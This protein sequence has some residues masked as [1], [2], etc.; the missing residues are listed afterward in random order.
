MDT[1]QVI[2]LRDFVHGIKH[3]NLNDGKER[4]LTLMI[5]V[6]NAYGFFNEA[7]HI[8]RWDDAKERFYVFGYNSVGTNPN[9]GSKNPTGF[10]ELSIVDYGQIQQFKV[11]LSEVDFDAVCT[12]LGSSLMPD[13]VRENTRMKLFTTTDPAYYI[14]KDQETHY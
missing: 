2:E 9:M 5:L 11:V 14:K 1:P 4:P 7:I 6:D 10:G 8:V 12:A 13:D 3:K